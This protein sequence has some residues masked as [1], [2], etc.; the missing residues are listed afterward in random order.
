M[1]CNHSNA[2]PGGCKSW[3]R[4]HPAWRHPGR[5]RLRYQWQKSVSLAESPRED[6]V[7]R[8]TPHSVLSAALSRSN[9]LSSLC[10][11][12]PSSATPERL[13]SSDEVRDLRP[14]AHKHTP[15]P[16]FPAH[17]SMLKRM[18]EKLRAGNQELPEERQLRLAYSFLRY[19]C[20][21][22]VL[23]RILQRFH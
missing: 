14:N 12:C 21:L 13:A 5:R 22:Q 3:R 10:Q 16:C 9:I 18:S 19:R 2:V 6:R 15:N 17:P 23:G 1:R 20:R 4:C 8:A 7:S 11:S